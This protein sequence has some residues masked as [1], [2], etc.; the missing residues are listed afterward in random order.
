[1][2]VDVIGWEQIK[3]VRSRSM[4]ST[5]NVCAHISTK[6]SAAVRA[7]DYVPGDIFSSSN[8]AA[9]APGKVS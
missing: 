6:P 1:M 5:A 8:N 3:C 7:F 4:L 9:D 2:C